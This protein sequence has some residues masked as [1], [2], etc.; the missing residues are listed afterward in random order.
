MDG[1]NPTGG[2]NQ[3]G[4]SRGSLTPNYVAGFIDGEGCFSVSIRPHPSIQDP[5]RWLIAP[6]FQA[7]QHRDNVVILEMIRDFFGC[8]RLTA[9]GPNRSVM[10]YSVYGVDPERVII[11]FFDRYPLISRKHEDFLKFREIVRLMRRKEHRG[12]RGFRRVVELAFSMNQR[13]KQRKYRIE[14]VLAKP[15]E[16][17]RRAVQ[18]IEFELKIQSDPHGDVGRAAEMTAP[19][20]DHPG[21]WAIKR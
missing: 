7:Y 6:V 9:K 4:R 8:G 3:Q 2:D 11:P 14:D 16:T 10:T 15:S 17:A 19:P 20:N 12:E 18:L 21:V 1:D 13:G 5:K